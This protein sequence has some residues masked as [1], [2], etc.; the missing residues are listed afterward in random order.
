MESLKRSFSLSY[1][2]FFAVF[3]GFSIINAYLCNVYKLRRCAV[4]CTRDVCKVREVNPENKANCCKR[5]SY[6]EIC[7]PSLCTLVLFSVVAKSPR[8]E[9]NIEKAFEKI[10]KQA[11]IELR[12]QG[13]ASEELTPLA[14]FMPLLS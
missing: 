4:P 2:H 10:F 12:P 1:C 6:D 13:L 11:H 9:T 3:F 7:K 5:V 14:F 8:L